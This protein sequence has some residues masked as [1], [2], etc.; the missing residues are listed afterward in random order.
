MVRV[1]ASL[2]NVQKSSWTK[3]P[4]AWNITTSIQRILRKDLTVACRAS[5]FIELPSKTSFCPFFI[6]FVGLL[7]AAKHLTPA[8]VCDSSYLLRVSVLLLHVSKITHIYFS[9]FIRARC[10]FFFSW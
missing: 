9:F 2:S 3:E 8:I 4:R 5:H 1:C 7:S 10:L 6:C